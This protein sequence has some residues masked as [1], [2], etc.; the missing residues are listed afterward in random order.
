MKISDENNGLN[1]RETEFLRAIG[2]DPR[3]PDKSY[4]VCSSVAAR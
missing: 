3:K 2:K 1:K 4:T